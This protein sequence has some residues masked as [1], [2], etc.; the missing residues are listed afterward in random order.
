MGLLGWGNINQQLSGLFLRHMPPITSESTSRIDDLL[1]LKLFQSEDKFSSEVLAGLLP[2]FIIYL[3]IM[4]FLFGLLWED[5]SIKLG[6]IFA[7]L[8][9]SVFCAPLF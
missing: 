5:N 2:Q 6:Q 9:F 1:I 7:E 3:A 4:F 8:F